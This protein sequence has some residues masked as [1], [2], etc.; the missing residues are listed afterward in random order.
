MAQINHLRPI[1][2]LL[3]L[4]V[5]VGLGFCQTNLPAEIAL[6]KEAGCGGDWVVP[7]RLAT[8]EELPFAVDTGSSLTILD[9]SLEPKLGKQVGTWTF[10]GW[11]EKKKLNVYAAPKLYLGKVPL[12]MGQKIAT[13]HLQHCKGILGMDCLRH[14]CI[15]LDFQA[16]SARFLDPDGVDVANLGKAFP[17]TFRRGCPFIHHPSLTGTGTNPNSRIDTGFNM[18]GRADV[19]KPPDKVYAVRLPK[20]VWDNQ[21]YTNLLVF[22][23]RADA[24]LLGLGFLAR[25][26]VTFDFPNAVLYLKQTSVGPLSAGK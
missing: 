7:I 8:G 9:K 14:Y 13:D 23:G 1:W 3:L 10:L 19:G 11:D 12:A 16:G 20:C 18:D 25:H 4:A 21:T 22:T 6:N 24:N 2:I 5:Q 15:Q 17:I 26:L